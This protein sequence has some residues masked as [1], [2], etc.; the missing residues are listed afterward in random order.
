MVA[1]ISTGSS[2]YGALLYNQ[3]KVDIGKGKV[4]LSNKIYGGLDNELTIKN[5][6]ESFE[7]QMP[8]KFRTEKP[9][10]HISLNPHPDDKIEEWQYAE[11]AKEYMEKMGYGDQPYVV[12]KHEDIDRH[13]LH[14]VSINVD[15]NGKKLDH[16]NDFYRSKK[17][18]RELEQK[19]GLR[20]AERKSR[21]EK[22]GF[23][24]NKVDATKG[25][26]KIQIGNVIKP[27]AV[28]YKFQ[29]FGEYRTL[30]S[31]YNICVEE[32]KGV[33]NGKPYEGL[34]YY[35]TNDKGEKISNPFK[36]SLYGKNVGY[37]S[38]YEKCDKHKRTIKDKKLGKD[39][40]TRILSATNGTNDKDKFVEK[41][42]EQNIDVVF[43]ENDAGRIYGATFI[44][45]NNHCVFN[46]SRLGK[47]FSANALND[48]FN[49]EPTQEVNQP[50]QQQPQQQ[51]GY[52]QY[53]DS[54][55][56]MGGL[57]DLPADGADDS[58][59]NLFRNRMKRKKK[60]GR[61]L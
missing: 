20:S 52:N 29:S 43:R 23:T 50:M 48:R 58:E 56:S 38:I 26:V 44:D 10:L 46:G 49:S 24:F 15:K 61:K 42:K 57:L 8:P 30:L 3:S 47:E 16:N 12:F 45:N 39:T 37:G 35:A 28:T 18:T 13:H 41:L 40:A 22:Q 55:F 53:D 51:L 31:H 21:E 32:S 2:L 27:L 34:I 59:E 25:N 9:I 11:I 14:I 19:Y 7:M 60:K 1:K 36:S 5:C 54:S 33:R 6:L 17:I 4:I